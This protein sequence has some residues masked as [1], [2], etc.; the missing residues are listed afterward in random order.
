MADSTIWWIIAGVLVVLELTTGT[1]YLLMLALG[2]AAGALVAHAGAGI[3][4][5]L[6]VAAAVGG[7]AAYLGHLWRKRHPI[8]AAAIDVL[9]VG[10]T[11]QIDAWQADGTAQIRYRGAPWVAVLRP[12]AAQQLG[13]HRI[14]ELMGS[15]LVV[16]PVG[17]SAH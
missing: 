11:V 1:F 7:V 16:E 10:E 3:T 12:G 14:T 15:R 5:Q 2:A 8:H 6:V 17:T 13:T 9:D 4:V